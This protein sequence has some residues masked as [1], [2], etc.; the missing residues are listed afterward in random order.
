MGGG[1]AG[2]GL[3]HLEVFLVIGGEELAAERSKT[4]FADAIVMLLAYKQAFTFN[5]VCNRNVFTAN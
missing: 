2:L 1:G 4:L 3:S 5:A